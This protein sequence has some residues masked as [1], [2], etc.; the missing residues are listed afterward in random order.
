MSRVHAAD[1]DCENRLRHASAA[2]DVPGS[3]RWPLT[4]NPGWSVL[5][6]YRL[7]PSPHTPSDMSPHPRRIVETR[8]TSL[9][10]T[11]TAG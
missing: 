11:F 7:K 4:T 1:A 10:F 6:A 8:N 9:L 2:H 3:L 5:T